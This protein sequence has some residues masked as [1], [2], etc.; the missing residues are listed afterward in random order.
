[1]CAQG[2]PVDMRRA[3]ELAAAWLPRQPIAGPAWAVRAMQWLCNTLSER[4]GRGELCPLSAAE[5]A[6]LDPLEALML[7]CYPDTLEPIDENAHW[8]AVRPSPTCGARVETRPRTILTLRLATHF[9]RPQ[10]LKAGLEAVQQPPFVHLPVLGE[11][12]R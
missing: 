9:S 7:R 10:A 8:L 12:S 6:L 5:Q 4:L 1:M 2:Q 11:Q 3:A